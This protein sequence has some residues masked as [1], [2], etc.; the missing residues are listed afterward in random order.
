ML[1]AIAGDIIGSP[2]EGRPT[3]KYNFPLFSR[4][5]TFTDDTVLTVALADSILNNIPYE[6]T[7]KQ[8]TRLYPRA[9]YGMSFL[10]W[11]DSDSRGPYNSYGNGSAMRVSPV[12]WTCSK[13]SE[14]L[15][16]AKESAEVTHNHPE[17]IRGAQATASAL[18]LARAGQSKAEIKNYIETRFGYDLSR[19][20]E[21]IKKGYHYDVTCQGSVPEAI[22]AFL[23]STNFEDAVR[24]AVALGGDSDTQACITGCIAEA[25]YSGVPRNIREKVFSILDSKLTGIVKKFLKKYVKY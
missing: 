22:I 1:G 6:K 25:F 7:L 4:G 16:K 3:K 8:Y 11:V 14:T 13:L 2:Y 9:G 10:Y 17:G 24:K 23:V 12:G 21:E 5:S 19:D 18:F 15:Q 20:Y